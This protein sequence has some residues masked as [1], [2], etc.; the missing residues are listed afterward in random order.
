VLCDCADPRFDALRI[1]AREPDLLPDR[2][3]KGLASPVLRAITSI[4]F[5]DDRPRHAAQAG[6]IDEVVDLVHALQDGEFT[7]AAGGH[8][9]HEGQRVETPIPIQCREDLL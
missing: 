7:P 1:D 9:R 8:L 3:A 6:P 2:L 5:K 4:A